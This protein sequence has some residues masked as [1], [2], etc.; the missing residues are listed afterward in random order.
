MR[1][2]SSRSPG[3]PFRSLSNP[4]RRDTVGRQYQRR[5]SVDQRAPGQLFALF[6]GVY[7]D[8]GLDQASSAPQANP[9]GQEV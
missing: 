2:N 6:Q 5:G 4:F 9:A 3:V 7:G 8:P 1:K